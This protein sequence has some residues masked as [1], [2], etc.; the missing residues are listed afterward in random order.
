M[1]SSPDQDRSTPDAAGV[2]IFP[3]G[4][5]LLVIALGVILKRHWPIGDGPLKTTP[6]GFWLGGAIV[7]SG[8]LGIMLPALLVMRRSGQSPNPL[9]PTPSIL[10]HGPFRYTRNP[11]YLTMIVACIG[12]A[13]LLANW[14]IV[15]L[16]PFGALL[17]QQLAIVPEE[18]YLTAKFGDEYRSYQ[19]QIRRWL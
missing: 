7:I 5:P 6:P 12:F 8:F 4:V 11:M 18:R 3:P 19:Q 15:V 9:K 17:L 14:W 2:S 1:P 16:T 13:V 10:T